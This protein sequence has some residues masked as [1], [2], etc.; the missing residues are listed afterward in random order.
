MAVLTIPD[1]QKTL[2]GSALRD[3]L[4]ERGVLYDVWEAATPFAKDTDQQAVLA[5]YAHV[6]EPFMAQG[7]YRTADVIVVHPDLPNLA[8]LEQKFKREHTHSEDEIRFFVEGDGYFWFNLGGDEPVFVVHGQAGDL[9]S[10]PAGTKHWFEMGPN[11]FLK[12]VRVF[13]EQAGWT[14]H[15]TDSGIDQRY[16]I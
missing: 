4:A 2:T 8:Q 6:L 10:V 1:L 3:Y 16:E 12:C 11:K 13:I 9:L 7:G 14:P 5:A 15:Y